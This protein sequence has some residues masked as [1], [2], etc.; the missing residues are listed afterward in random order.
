MTKSNL[1][2]ANAK[3]QDFSTCDYQKHWSYS[4]F[5]KNLFICEALLEHNRVI[6]IGAANSKIREMLSINFNCHP[7]YIRYDYNNMYDDII[8]LDVTKG[9]PQRDGS[10]DAVIFSEVLEHLPRGSVG[11]VMS[12]L[13]RVIKLKGS[14]LLTTPT[15][16]I[17]D[18][19]VW[20]DVHDQ[21]Y[22]RAEVLAITEMAGFK[23]LHEMPWHTRSEL[24][25]DMFSPGLPWGFR[26]AVLSTLVGPERAT[27]IALHLL[28]VE[29]LT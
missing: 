16:L 12:E 8:E 7:K 29:N 22:T 10:Q 21:E 6:E 20:P 27:Q 26:R 4:I 17:K 23:V 3:F 11:F 28:K 1:T 9:I 24:T 14:L 13:N 2:N 25:V 18:E 19:M 5:I 15:P